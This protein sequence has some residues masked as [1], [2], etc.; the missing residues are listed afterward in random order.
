MDKD[1]YVRMIDSY[2][3][4]MYRVAYTILRNPHDCKDA[5]QEAALK[6]WEK[7]FT[8]RDE[9]RFAS[10]ITRIV[11]NACYDIQRK[12]KRTISLEEMASEP[13]IQPPDRILHWALQSLPEKL[14]LPLML[15]YSEGMDYREIS[16]ALRL[17][18]STVRG[19]IHRAKQA[20][21]K[22]LGE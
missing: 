16:L 18:E 6:A 4:M 10:W 14:R 22:E 13:S 19:R 8:L 3:G 5:L 21:R 12:R 20:L 11:I 7:R 1:M 2:S 17:P 15:Q 9:Q